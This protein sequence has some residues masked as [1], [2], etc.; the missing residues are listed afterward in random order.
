MSFDKKNSPRVA[1]E[2]GEQSFVSSPEIA[3]DVDF[4]ED[5]RKEVSYYIN[6]L[7]YLYEDYLFYFQYFL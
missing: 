3:A 2:P 4:Q 1:F 7:D 5:L 6:D